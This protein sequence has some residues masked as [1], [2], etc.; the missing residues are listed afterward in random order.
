MPKVK[1]SPEAQY[2]LIGIQ[3]YIEKDLQSPAAAKNVVRR[4][5]QKNQ[6]LGTAP[7]IGAQLSTFIDIDT[8]YRL[9]AAGNYY[10]FYRY[11]ENDK[12]CYIDRILYK[13]RDYL[14]ILFGN[15]N[16][17]K[18]PENDESIDEL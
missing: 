7:K 4:I 3:A 15:S 6:S 11:I 13:R 12:T 14:T 1:Y 16:D 10:S 2:D 17:N 9:L 18:G 8:D 5:L